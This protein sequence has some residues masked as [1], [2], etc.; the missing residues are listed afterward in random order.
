MPFFENSDGQRLQLTR[1]FWIYWAVTVPIT[2]LTVGVWHFWQQSL[3]GEDSTASDRLREKRVGL[4]K[5]L[6]RGEDKEQSMTATEK[7]KKTWARPQNR[8]V[9]PGT[10]ELR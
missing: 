9:E 7:L 3:K 10:Y 1:D 8:D 5:I 4:A 2:I 6:A